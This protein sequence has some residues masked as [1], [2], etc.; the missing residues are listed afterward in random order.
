MNHLELESMDKK[1]RLTKI[2]KVYDRIQKWIKKNQGSISPSEMNVAQAALREI[3]EL[4][5]RVDNGYFP[6]LTKDIMERL[7]QLWKQYKV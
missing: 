7:N 1:D 4:T 2:T 3:E 5:V 6:T